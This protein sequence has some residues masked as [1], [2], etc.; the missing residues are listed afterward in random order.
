MQ[1]RER[2]KRGKRVDLGDFSSLLLVFTL[3]G[4]NYYEITSQ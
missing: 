1:K 3:S 4:P 2:K